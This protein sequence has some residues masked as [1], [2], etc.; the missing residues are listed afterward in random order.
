MTGSDKDVTA[1]LLRE[2]TIGNDIAKFQQACLSN[3]L[4]SGCMVDVRRIEGRRTGEKALEVGLNAA[5]DLKTRMLLRLK[6]DVTGA[7]K[8][9]TQE[10]RVE[11]TK[12]TVNND[13]KGLIGGILGLLGY[14]VGKTVKVARRD[15]AILER[16]LN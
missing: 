5:I 3:P 15:V 9:D 16:E 14:G 12:L 10:R 6:I 2:G 1:V 4:V 11:I 8:L 13:V 7:G